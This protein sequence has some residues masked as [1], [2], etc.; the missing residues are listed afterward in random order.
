MF[1]KPSEIDFTILPDSQEKFERLLLSPILEVLYYE[2]NMS[3]S[4]FGEEWQM[5]AD[6]FAGQ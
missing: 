4:D 1:Y 2:G 3:P 5:T 6:S